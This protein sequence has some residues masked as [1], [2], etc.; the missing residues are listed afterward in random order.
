VSLKTLIIET[1]KKDHK[2]ATSAK[3]KG[4]CTNGSI[5]WPFLGTKMGIQIAVSGISEID[6]NLSIEITSVH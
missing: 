2:W 5:K 1:T 6:L 4:L 3:E